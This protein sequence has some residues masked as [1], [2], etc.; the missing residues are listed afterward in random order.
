MTSKGAHNGLLWHHSLRPCVGV[1]LASA[2]Y[3]FLAGLRTVSSSSWPC[4]IVSMRLQMCES[5]IILAILR[6]VSALTSFRPAF[7][8]RFGGGLLSIELILLTDSGPG[9]RFSPYIIFG[10]RV[11]LSDATS[12]GLRSMLIVLVTADCKAR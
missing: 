2:K 10:Y 1:H 7:L 4:N 5:Y 8:S 3:R 11:K 6:A 12:G 9:C